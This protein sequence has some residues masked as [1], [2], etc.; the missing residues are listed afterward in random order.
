MISLQEATLRW[1]AQRAR[2]Q[3]WYPT[4][5]EILLSIH[6]PETLKHLHISTQSKRAN[7]E[8]TVKDEVAILMKYANL[9]IEICAARSWSQS[10]FTICVP[11]A[12]AM[13]HHSETAE[14][15]RGMVFVKKVWDAVLHAE[16]VSADP[17]TAAALKESLDQILKHMAWHKSQ[18]ALEIYL[19]CS[20]GEWKYMDPETR[21]MAFSL[22]GTP[23]N[24]K[25]FLEDCFAHLADLAKRVSRHL[26]MSKSLATK[27][28]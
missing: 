24:T 25:H 23:A 2:G 21:E 9:A 27:L 26:K 5:V 11:Y 18:I 3:T 16:R 28:V 7:D 20:S 19:V 14:R 1:R 8:N 13:V 22:Y 12:F 4:V 10:Q 6:K 15:E 17:A